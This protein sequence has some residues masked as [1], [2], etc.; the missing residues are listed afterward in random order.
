MP[1]VSLKLENLKLSCSEEKIKLLV[2]SSATLR[3]QDERFRRVRSDE[4]L[5][6]MESGKVCIS[7]GP[8]CNLGFGF[9]FKNLQLDGP[10]EKALVDELGR[11]VLGAPWWAQ[12]PV[13]PSLKSPTPS[14]PDVGTEFSIE[15]H[16]N[17]PNLFSNGCPDTEISPAADLHVPEYVPDIRLVGIKFSFTFEPIHKKSLPIVPKELATE[18]DMLF[19]DACEDDLDPFED[20]MDLDAFGSST[21]RHEASFGASSLLEGVPWENHSF[22]E[23]RYYTDGY[24]DILLYQTDHSS[25][26]L[27]TPEASMTFDSQQNTGMLEPMEPHSSI[28]E[29]LLKLTTAKQL[30]D[31]TLRTLLGGHQTK[32]TPNIKVWKPRPKR[33]L[34]SIMPL[35][36]SPG[37]KNAMSE[38]S[39]FINTI[40]TTLSSLSKTSQL[41]SLQKKLSTIHENPPARSAE[42]HPPRLNQTIQAHV[43]RMMQTT[44]YEPIASRRLR[45]SVIEE[46]GEEEA[47]SGPPSRDYENSGP[48]RVDTEN[49]SDEVVDAD[50]GFEDLFGEELLSDGEMDMLFDLEI[51]RNRGEGGS[52]SMLL[53]SGGD[54][55]MLMGGD[56]VHEDVTRETGEEDSIFSTWQVERDDGDEHILYEREFLDSSIVKEELEEDAEMI[57]DTEPDTVHG[58]SSMYLDDPYINNE[59]I[60]I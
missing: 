52:C 8:G 26:Q 53:E 31:V 33:P 4:L 34:S 50:E 15:I 7:R 47:R 55:S 35:L 6:L 21:P 58:Y 28:T 9:S 20:I 19:E 41:P 36:W 32:H 3:P 2:T 42:T 23:D 11:F 12:L 39:A 60:L 43:F 48:P 16:D 51:L 30:T 37:F 29:P 45:P 5:N 14:C 22:V 25:V 44:L 18:D 46:S 27:P 56:E 40:S 49:G 13:S 24:D 38:R 59:A 17:L 1:D 10:A 54:S 57:M